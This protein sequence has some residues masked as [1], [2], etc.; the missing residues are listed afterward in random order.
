MP[1]NIHASCVLLGEAG[2]HMHADARAGI[3]LLGQSGSGKSQLALRLIER[4]AILVSDDRTELH[5]NSD[6]LVA[7]TPRNLAGLLEV[8]GMGVV[9]LPFAPQAQIALAVLL[10][11]E[12]PERYPEREDFQP[13][14]QLRHPV[15]RR[16]PLIRLGSRELAGPAKIISAIVAFHHSAKSSSCSLSQVIGF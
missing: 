10:Q 1:V 11:D 13:P 6:V 4:G 9:E 5:S 3:L 12:F 16:P 8:R 14:E 2:T 7:Q 15:E